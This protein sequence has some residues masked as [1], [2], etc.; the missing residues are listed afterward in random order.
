MFNN[1]F[2]EID[3]GKIVLVL[4][5]DMSAAFDTIDHELLLKPLKNSYGIDKLVLN[6]LSSYLN[7]CSFSVNINDSFS[8]PDSML[9]GVPQGSILGPILFILY[10]KHLQ[11]IAH[12]FNLNIQLYADDT[13]L[14][15]SFNPDDQYLC[16]MLC[17]KVAECINKMKEWFSTNYLK[18]NEGQNK[19]SVIFKTIC[20]QEI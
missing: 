10:T 3:N 1:I 17:N 20:F 2:K 12:N 9:Y 15:I 7:H 19:I 16:T 5:L 18:L 6:W 8:D 4:L 11:H 13:Q 14:Y